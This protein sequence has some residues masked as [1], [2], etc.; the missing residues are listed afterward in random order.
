MDIVGNDFEEKVTV[1]N[2]TWALQHGFKPGENGFKE[3]DIGDAD[4]IT[5]RL[6]MKLWDEGEE[7]SKRL[8]LR[9]SR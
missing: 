2:E 1:E 7:V 4:A 5:K 3:F 8:V 9:E 6:G